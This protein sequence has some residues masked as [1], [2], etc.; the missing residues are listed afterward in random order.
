[1]WYQQ[2]YFGN[3]TNFKWITIGG[4]YSGAFSAWFRLKYPH[5]TI[6]SLASSGVVHA[7]LDFV[8][9]DQQVSTSVGSKCASLLRQVTAEAEQMIWANSSSNAKVKELFNATLLIEDGDFFYYIA[10]KMAESVQYGY[11]VQLCTP[12]LAAHKSGASLLT[13][14]ANYTVNFAAGILGGPLGYNTAA[15]LNTT[16]DENSAWRQ[17]WYQTCAEFAYFQCAPAQNSIRSSWV[18]LTYHI[19]M[20]KLLF[21]GLVPNVDAT[22]TYYGANYTAGTNIWFSNGS[23]DPWQQASVMHWIS[24]EEPLAFVNCTN[25]GHCVDLRGCP[26]GC[27]DPNNLNYIRGQI[28]EEVKNWIYW[29]DHTE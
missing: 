15:L 5:L 25:C 10:D 28:A 6:G 21:N 2:E 1:V 27:L 9:F 14:F 7:I 8:E 22:N 3:A 19:D 24:D 11:Q 12:L 16:T 18:N 20:C 4:S 29:A 17:W 23:Q 13:T 26:G